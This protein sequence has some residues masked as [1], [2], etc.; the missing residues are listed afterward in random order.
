MNLASGA[1]HIEIQNC[2]RKRPVNNAAS[3]TVV[4]GR[5]SSS[6]M[7]SVNYSVVDFNRFLHV[8]MMLPSYTSVN[9]V[10]MKL[11]LPND[12]VTNGALPKK[13]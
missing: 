13:L 4:R 9:H 1:L 6:D 12:Y 11:E 5:C 2:R 7:F 3:A 10:E 8:V